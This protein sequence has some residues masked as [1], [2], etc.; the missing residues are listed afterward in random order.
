MPKFRINGHIVEC[1]DAPLG[2]DLI[3]HEWHG[4]LPVR[5]KKKPVKVIVYRY[6]PRLGGELQANWDVNSKIRGCACHPTEVK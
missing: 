1:H 4:L 3:T 6:H 5:G 2:S